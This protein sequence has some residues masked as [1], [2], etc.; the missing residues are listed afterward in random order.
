MPFETYVLEK[1]ANAQPNDEASINCD[2]REYGTDEAARSAFSSVKLRLR[3][4][5][6]WNSN[7]GLSAYALFDEAGRQLAS[8]EI[9]IGQ[10]L[11]ITLAASGKSDWVRIEHIHDTENELVITVKPTF[12]PTAEPPQTGETSHFFTAAARNN[13]CAVRDGSRVGV[14]VIG[15]HEK[16]NSGHTS[17]ILETA[18]NAAVANL[19]YYLGIQKAEWN[20][21][22]SSMLQG[23]GESE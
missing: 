10:F 9:Q 4:I 22:C 20:K 15:L 14:Y 1:E 16:L 12:D 18:R 3:D 17:G 13:F 7:S 8:N 21:F 2:V 19:G 5:N 11:R 23:A 6:A